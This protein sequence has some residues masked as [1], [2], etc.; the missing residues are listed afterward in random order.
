MNDMRMALRR[1][2][3]PGRGRRPDLPRDRG[4][5]HHVPARRPLLRGEGQAPRRRRPEGAARAR[6]Q[7]R[8]SSTPTAE[9]RVPVEQLAVGDR[10]VV[11]PGEKVATDGVVEEGSSRGRH[12]HAHRRVR[13]GRGR[14]RRRGRG[15]DRQRRRPPDRPRHQGRR[16][17]RAR[18]DRPPGRG[19]ADRQGAGPAARRPHLRRL[20][21]GRH[22]ARASRTLGFW[23]GTGESATFAFTAAVAVL[24]IACPCALG[25]A[26]PTALMVGTGRGAQLGLLIKG[27]EVL[28]STRRVDTIVLDKTGTVTT[29]KMSARSR[30]TVADGVDRDEALRLVGALEHASEHPIA[31]AIAA[32]AA[33]ERPAAGGRGLRQPRGPRRRGRRRRPRADRRPARAAGATGRMHLPPEL[34][35]AR[36]AAEARGQTAIAA[37]WDGRATRRLRRRRHRQADLRGGGRLAEG[38]RPAARAADRRQRDDRP[39]GRRRGRHRRGDRRGPARRQ[40]RRRPPPAG[41]GPRRR[42]GRRRRQRRARARPGR[43][44]PERSAPAPTS[45]SRPPTSRSSPAT[46]APP[47][48]PSASAARR[49]ARS[50]RT[51]AGRSATTSPRSRWP[52]SACSTR[53]S[54]SLAMVFSSVS[55]VA[56]ALRLRRF[57]T[58]R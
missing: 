21:P 34:D 56:N 1:H 24:I 23:L 30:S 18:P 42:D 25:L 57:Q 40:G 3:Q 20:R 44:R 52:R 9:R 53:S 12:E 2:P 26:T 15:R 27:P 7:G 14:A 49:C 58:Q 47:P 35:A 43:P 50:S 22:R 29:G 17:H 48:T 33:A 11:R 39:R 55:V 41:R 45:R 5:R 32:A 16:R 31:Q 4:H 37:G 8:R 36:R 46:C 28:E 38:A 54:P 10:F 13:A 19:R 6:R 51:S